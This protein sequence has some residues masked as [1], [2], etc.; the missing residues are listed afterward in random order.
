MPAFPHFSQPRP[1]T[2]V[3]S[4]GSRDGPPIFST[5]SALGA[6]GTAHD[7]QTRRT[8]RCPTMPASD[9]ATMNGWTPRSKQ[10][11]NRRRRIV[12]VERAQQQMAGL[13]GLQRDARG[14]RVANLADQDHVGVLPQDGS[15]AAG[16]RQRRP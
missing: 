13:R 16:E 10:P 12:G 4:A 6:C 3:P 1:T 5:V 8:S 14:F 2:H 7:G 9:A 11:G 15:Q